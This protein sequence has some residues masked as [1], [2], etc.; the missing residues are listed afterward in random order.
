MSQKLIDKKVKKRLQLIPYLFILFFMSAFLTAYAYK[1]PVKNN[2]NLPGL[3][4]EEMGLNSITWYESFEE[5]ESEL[6]ALAESSNVILK[7]DRTSY[8]G[9]YPLYWLEIGDRTKPA[10]FFNG[11]LHAHNEKN[12]THILMKFA[13]ELVDGE[14]QSDFNEYILENYCVIII[15]M[16]NPYGYFASEEGHHHNGHGASVPNIQNLNWHNNANY[17]YYSGVN[18]NRNFDWG[19]ENYINIPWSMQQYWNGIDYGGANYIMMPNPPTLAPEYELYDYKGESAFSEPETQLI[20]DLFD[21]YDVIAFFDYHTMNPWQTNNSSNIPARYR[22]DLITLIDASRA[23]V[24]ARHSGIDLPA[25]VHLDMHSYDGG[26]A[27]FASNWAFSK[28]GVFAFG[29]ETGT[30][31]PVELYSDMYIEL[32]YRSLEYITKSNF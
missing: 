22:N 31:L 20:R 23:R 21:R 14:T 30:D 1:Q 11:L 2:I 13:E 10:I 4:E 9:N 7:S 8:T 29:W 19:W 18:L 16:A 32:F 3:I 15:P 27:P 25:T 17:G 26:N 12:I 24:N 5:Y 28:K 6:E